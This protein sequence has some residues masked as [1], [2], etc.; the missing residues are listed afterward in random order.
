MEG[1]RAIFLGIN[2]DYVDPSVAVVRD[3]K[4]L[5]FAEE[6]R[7][8]RNKHALGHYPVHALRFCLDR[9]GVGIEQVRAI[10]INWNLTAYTDG[11]MENFYRSV[12]SEWNVDVQTR[13]WQRSRLRKRSREKYLEAHRQN[14]QRL[15]GEVNLPEFV[16][17]PHHYTHA[18]QAFRQS[19]FEQAVCLTIDGSGDQHCTVVWRCDQHGIVPLKEILM[20]HS[21]GWVYAAF[22]EYLGFRAY[23]G[24]YKVMGLAAYGRHSA[25]LS[26]KVGKVLGMD[27]DGI[28]YHVDPG[29]IHYGNHHYSG[30][31][32]D[33]LV[34]LFGRPPRLA[35]DEIT[36]WH[37][38]LAR[39]VQ[40][41][42]EVAVEGLVRWAVAQTG[43]DAVCI[44]G[45]VGLNIK[46]NSRIYHLPEVGDF[47]AHP[48]CG[49]S[50]AAAGSALVACHQ[51]CGGS[52]EKLSTLA[53]GNADDENRIKQVL[54]TAKLKYDRVENLCRVVADDLVNGKIVGWFQ[55]RMEAGPRALG[56]RSIL[57][58]PRSVENRDKVN[59]V[60]KFREYWRP[61]CPSMTEESM[62]RYF[63]KFTGAYFMNISFF[64]N[65]RLKREAPAIVHVDGTCRVQMVTKDVLP[66]FHQLISE[67]EIRTG[68]PVLLNTSFNVKGEPVVATVTDA[69]RTFWSTGLDTLAVGP[70]IIRKPL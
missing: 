27:P 16:D 11:T 29:F 18:F 44:S 54:D 68:V 39:A 19:P 69:L 25:E 50:G 41:A 4:V 1:T 51:I 36:H 22:T 34:N 35:S 23:D 43:I 32:T 46:M 30:R 60:I 10:G 57:A 55:G 66:L 58:D 12:Q 9:A 33:R 52:P 38:D 64:A 13:E 67:F 21:L 14:L 48:L 31:F 63:D 45:G 65:D 59:S 49:D 62:A 42:L 3:G 61:F 2:N 17:I 8:V 53:L 7:F 20:P 6:E 5:A 26:E 15:F 47:F 28:A 70:F 37:E 56:Q 40:E 24:E